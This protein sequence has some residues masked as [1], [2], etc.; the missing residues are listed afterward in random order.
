VP[1]KGNKDNPQCDIARTSRGPPSIEIAVR[2]L[3]RA[4]DDDFDGLVSISDLSDLGESPNFIS[5]QFSC[6]NIFPLREDS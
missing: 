1:R 3:F 2:T 6:M 4:L 5:T